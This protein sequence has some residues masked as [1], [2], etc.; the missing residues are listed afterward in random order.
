M[1]IA[2]KRWLAASAWFLVLLFLSTFSAYGIAV[3]AQEVGVNPIS[4]VMQQKMLAW[5]LGAMFFFMLAVSAWLGYQFARTGLHSQSMRNLQHDLDTAQKNLY[6]LSE[7][8]ADL[9]WTQN[10]EGVFTSCS[11]ALASCTGVPI[12]KI[13]G[14]NYLSILGVVNTGLLAQYH[15]TVVLGAQHPSVDI[16]LTSA[17]DGKERIFEV[18]K[19]PILN[20]RG[21]LVA[22]QSVARDVT[23]RRQQELQLKDALGRLRML[24]TCVEQLNDVILVSE[25]EPVDMPGPRI[26]YVNP[27]FERMTGYSSAEV[28]GKTPRILQGPRTQLKEVARIRKA[29]KAWKSVRAELVNYTKDGREF[30]VELNINPVADETGYFTHWVAVQ[31]EITDRKINN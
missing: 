8:N 30:W 16:R 23:L 22:V 1:N 31:R 5:A 26:I 12:Q 17:Y 4:L 28:I 27:A 10:A 19:T 14:S 3:M 18:N 21:H 7:Q 25:A 6:L 11:P 9:L 20:E 13:M 24:Q 15:Q 2:W 29:L